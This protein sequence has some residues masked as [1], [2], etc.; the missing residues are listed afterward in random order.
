MVFVAKNGDLRV[1]KLKT[2][3]APGLLANACYTRAECAHAVPT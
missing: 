3:H 1:Y 2:F